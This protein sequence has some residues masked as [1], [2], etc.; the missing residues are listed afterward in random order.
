M[1]A[2]FF[3]LLYNACESHNQHRIVCHQ[4]RKIRIIRREKKNFFFPNI[5]KYYFYYSDLYN[6]FF[7]SPFSKNRMRKGNFLIYSLFIYLLLNIVYF[8]ENYDIC[9]CLVRKWSISFFEST[10][11]NTH[12]TIVMACV[13]LYYCI[14]EW[15]VEY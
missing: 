9:V 13:L 14:L 8:E 12:A 3:L 2:F 1:C 10:E 11:N 5:M 7:L 6:F 4:K 15:R